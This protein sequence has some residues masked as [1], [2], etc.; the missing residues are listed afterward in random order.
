MTTDETREPS[1]PARIE[2]M[3]PSP[4]TS[5]VWYSVYCRDC[6]IE[7][8]MAHEK[9]SPMLIGQRNRHNAE[10]HPP[11]PS[12]DREKLIAEAKSKAQKAFPHR[13]PYLEGGAYMGEERSRIP[14]REAYARGYVDAAEALTSET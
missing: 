6:G 1:G 9:D 8:G 3:P 2:M 13:N 7:E 14:L 12:A 10:Y 11:A 5:A 4:E